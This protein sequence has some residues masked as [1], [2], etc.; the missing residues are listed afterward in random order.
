MKNTSTIT[1]P[2][3]LSTLAIAAMAFAAI[4]ILT[5]TGCSTVG[6]AVGSVQGI[7]DK[8]AAQYGLTDA[9]QAAREQVAQLEAQKVG[10]VLLPRGA[11]AMP[12]I[13][14]DDFGTPLTNGV[15]LTGWYKVQRRI[16]E[17]VSVP[18]APPTSATPPSIHPL[19]PGLLEGPITGT[20]IP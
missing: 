13:Y 14:E 15:T 3:T 2:A 9:L 7:N 17:R 4:I 19:E 20:V 8:L 18:P 10:R 5:C 6:A 1:M 11:V 16:A 12:E